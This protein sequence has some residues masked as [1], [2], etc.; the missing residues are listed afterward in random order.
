MGKAVPRP[1]G[2]PV[3]LKSGIQTKPQRIDFDYLDG[4]SARAER[5]LRRTEDALIEYIAAEER[6]EALYDGQRQQD[7]AE[8]EARYPALKKEGVR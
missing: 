7:R 8:L 1:V 6:R 4:L 3:G 5:E 2:H